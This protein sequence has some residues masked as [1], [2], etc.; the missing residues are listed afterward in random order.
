MNR[1][2]DSQAV[3]LHVPAHQTARGTAKQA[4]KA[5]LLGQNTAAAARDALVSEKRRLEGVARA[6]SGRA[7]QHERTISGEKRR[8]RYRGSR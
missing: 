4:A 2:T 8:C 7:L 5:V 6:L 3:R 1:N